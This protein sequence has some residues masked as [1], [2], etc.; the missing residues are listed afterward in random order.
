MQWHK[1]RNHDSYVE[2]KCNLTW[3][4][5]SFLDIGEK[6]LEPLKKGERK[7]WA[8]IEPFQITPMKT[9][10]TNI[11]KA[12]LEICCDKKCPGYICTLYCI[13]PCCIDLNC[14]R[15][16]NSRDSLAKIY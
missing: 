13:Y 11:T 5:P 15:P 7:E 3:L 2:S 14:I 4:E 8:M 6:K 16:F 12:D 9:A 1:G 10:N